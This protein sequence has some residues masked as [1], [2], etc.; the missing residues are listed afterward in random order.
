MPFHIGHINVPASPVFPV[1]VLTLTCQQ[2]G[3]EDRPDPAEV[4]RWWVAVCQE[5]AQAVLP[6]WLTPGDDPNPTLAE[7]TL[8]GSNQRIF[9]LAG[10]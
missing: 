8:F 6:S 7:A 3:A 1:L 2:C 10:R 4:E 9:K 5:T